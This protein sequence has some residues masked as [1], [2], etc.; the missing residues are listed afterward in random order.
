[1]FP[2]RRLLLNGLKSG[3]AFHIAGEWK[4]DCAENEFVA[5][6]AYYWNWTMFSHI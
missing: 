3:V 1:M 4:M 5:L 2:N 6:T